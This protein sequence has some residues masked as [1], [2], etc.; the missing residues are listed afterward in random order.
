VPTLKNPFD[1]ALYPML[2]WEVRPRTIIE[3]GSY[4]GGRALWFSDTMRCFGLP[5]HIHAFD[6]DPV[7]DWCTPEI[8]FHRADA[9]QLDRDIAPDFMKSLARPLLVIEDASHQKQTTR[10]ALEFFDR[11]LEPGEYI[12][13][14]DGIVTEL[15]LAKSFTGG[16]QEAVAE[17]LA[18]HPADYEIDAK[19]CDWYGRNVTWAVNGFLRRRAA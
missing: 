12:V 15:G 14:E 7:T 13:V 4:R 11:W 6:I 3:I 9:E 18:A 2:L 8:T 17:F 5:V 1:L 10:A 19:Y 16:P